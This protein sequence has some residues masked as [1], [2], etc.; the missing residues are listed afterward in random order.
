MLSEIADRSELIGYLNTTYTNRTKKPL[1]KILIFN[2]KILPEQMIDII[3]KRN[4]LKHVYNAKLKHIDENLFSIRIRKQFIDKI[5]EGYVL[6]DTSRKDI[7]I[8]ITDEKN[9]FVRFIV[10]TLFNKLYP[11]ISRI[12]LNS[13]QIKFIIEELK[14]KYEGNI[15]LNYISAN[16]KPRPETL[17]LSKFSQGTVQRWKVDTEKELEELSK[18]YRVIVKHLSFNIY[19]RYNMPLLECYISRTGTCKLQY[20]L[21]NEFYNEIILLIIKF[22]YEL[23]KFYSNRERYIYNGKVELFPIQIQYKTDFNKTQLK[24]L[25]KNINNKYLTSIIYSGN[26][27][28]AANISDYDDGSSFGLTVLKNKVTITPI[29]RASPE[30][31]WKLSNTL[32]EILGD[33]NIIN[34]LT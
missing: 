25:E 34:V 29:V 5:I 16:I 28:F 11:N 32:Q 7:W 17:E 12:Y 27:Y 33:G 10:E 23:K 9:Y 2:V 31:I 1:L 21:F 6:V 4:D 20:G 22:G 19:D 24:I 3:Q 8:T 18:T 13:S 26:P 30:S 14:K 15:K